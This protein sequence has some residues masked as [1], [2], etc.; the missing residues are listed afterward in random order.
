MLITPPLGEPGEEFKDLLVVG[1]EDVGAVLV[2]QHPGAVRTVVGVAADVAP[3]LRHQHA[4]A[5]FRQ[6]PGAHAAGEAGSCNQYV[7][8]IVQIRFRLFSHLSQYN[9]A[10][11]KNK[12]RND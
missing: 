3:A 12:L 2:N 7:K 5:L 11:F 9:T 4:P 6:T 10:A 1:V 8:I